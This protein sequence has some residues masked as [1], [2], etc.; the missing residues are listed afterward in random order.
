MNFI[1]IFYAIAIIIVLAFWLGRGRSYYRHK[2]S[3]SILFISP[4]RNWPLILAFLAISASQIIMA[5]DRYKMGI[6]VGGSGLEELIFWVLLAGFLPSGYAQLTKIT[7]GGILHNG[8][9]S[10][11]EDIVS[12][13]W[14]KRD[15]SA[16]RLI[17]ESRVN[18]FPP[19]SIKLRAKMEQ[20][21][22][23]EQLLRTYLDTHV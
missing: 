22:L 12:W 20:N 19:S 21:S 10:T 3:G 5:L 6:N 13:E 15:G 2:K 23:L 4:F 14:D 18:L 16:L 11:W 17:V 1:F 9:F 7:E 8:H